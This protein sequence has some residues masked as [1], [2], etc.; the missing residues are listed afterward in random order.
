MS[1]IEWRESFSIGL[2]EVDGEHRALIDMINAL[3][4]SLG[5]QAGAGRIVAALGEIHARIAAHFALE[6][7]AMRQLDYA[8]R[9]EHKADHE[10]LLDELLDIMDSV[11]SPADYDRTVLGKRLDDWF[12]GHFRTHDLRLHAWIAGRR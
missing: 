9:G 6:E 5:P 1:L 8:A 11:E 7:R 2:A 4:A 3:H 12:V 10:R